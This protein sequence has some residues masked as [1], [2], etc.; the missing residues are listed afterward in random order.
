MSIEHHPRERMA[1]DRYTIELEKS[2]SR[3]AKAKA[4]V[5]GYTKLEEYILELLHHAVYRKKLSLRGKTYDEVIMRL[6]AKPTKIGR[7]REAWAKRHGLW[8]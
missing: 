3:A 7:K 4:R 2:F 5:R 1:Y 6:I 8:Q